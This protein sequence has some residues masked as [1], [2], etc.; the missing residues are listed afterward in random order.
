MRDA[1]HRSAEEGRA[2]LVSVTGVAGIGKSRLAWELEKYV[3][4]L[5]D[6]YLFHR[7]RCLSYGEGVAFWAL[8]EIVRMRARVGEDEGAAGATA[9]IDA[10]LA[11]YVPVAD[12]REWVRP[13]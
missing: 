13:A 7:G 12:E 5:A 4:G 6:D 10:M 8:A 1:L 3:D 9:K 11:E 2:E